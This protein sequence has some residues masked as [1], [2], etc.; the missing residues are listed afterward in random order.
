MKTCADN[1]RTSANLQLSF[2][3]IVE[4]QYTQIGPKKYTKGYTRI[5]AHARRSLPRPA[6]S[7][8]P[9]GYQC[10]ADTLSIPYW[11]SSCLYYLVRVL[12]LYRRVSKTRCKLQRFPF[13]TLFLCLQLGCLS[14]VYLSTGTFST[15]KAWLGGASFEICPFK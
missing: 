6:F 3:Y 11:Y 9:Q 8:T 2:C 13:C 1:M 14:L 10:C 4:G 12:M 5:P 15:L 7:R